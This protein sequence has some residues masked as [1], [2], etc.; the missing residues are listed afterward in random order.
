M[1]SDIISYLSDIE[2]GPSYS[3]GDLLRGIM[4]RASAINRR[5]NIDMCLEIDLAE[6]S[7]G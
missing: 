5:T 1:L 2:A 3:V 4:H 7:R 6:F